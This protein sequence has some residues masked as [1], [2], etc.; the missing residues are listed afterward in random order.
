MRFGDPP[1]L[2]TRESWQHQ[3]F[4]EQAVPLSV[5]RTWTEQ[6]Y[7]RIRYGFIPQAMEDKWFIFL[8]ED[9]LYVHRSWTGL[10]VYKLSFVREGT[11]YRASSAFAGRDPGQPSEAEDRYDARLLVSLIDTLLLEQAGPLPLPAGL[12]AGIATELHHSAVIGAGRSKHELPKM[13]FWLWLW[14]WLKWLLRG[15]WIRL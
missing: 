8:E 10:A 1:S 13:S 6:E 3:P 15:L 11:I 7:E 4:P 9:T 2:A 5:E 12:P 14:H